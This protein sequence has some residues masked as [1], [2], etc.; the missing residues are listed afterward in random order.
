MR[1]HADVHG[2]EKRRG[3]GRGG[4]ERVAFLAYLH[5][6]MRPGMYALV[7]AEAYV[8]VERHTCMQRGIRSDAQ[9]HIRDT[10]G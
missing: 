7:H 8:H 9:R 6:C 10:Q 4:K 1:T 5:A 2:G 3:A